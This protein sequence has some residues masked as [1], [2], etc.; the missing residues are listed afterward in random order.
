MKIYPFCI[1]YLLPTFNIAVHL[2]CV[3]NN[4]GLGFMVFNSTFNNISVISLT[5]F[6]NKLMLNTNQSINQSCIEQT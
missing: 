6:I 2:M 1:V 5:N 4:L 3:M